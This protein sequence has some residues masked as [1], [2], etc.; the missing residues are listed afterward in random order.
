MKLSLKI[1][2]MILVILGLTACGALQREDIGGTQ[3][4]EN[5]AYSTEIVAIDG[6]S[7]SEQATHI[8]DV[9][10]FMT[11]AARVNSVNRQLLGTLEAIITPTPVLVEDSSVEFSSLP[12][13]SQGARLYL[14]TGMTDAVD[15]N[16][17]VT[18]PRT[19]FDPGV[20]RIYATM[21]IYNLTVDTVMGIEWYWENQLIFSD[22]WVSDIDSPL[23]CLWFE[24]DPARVDLVSGE[25]RALGY[26]DNFPAINAMP[27]VINGQ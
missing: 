14:G 21:I 23:H 7:V 1:P 10:M 24:L 12:S 22:S 8:A 13:D 2:L 16:G 5:I 4:A 19:N 3:I 17:C 6:T 11:E 20:Q 27:F 15:E 26:A 25:W 18:T 9:E